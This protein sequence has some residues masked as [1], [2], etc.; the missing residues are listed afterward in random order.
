MF[1]QAGDREMNRRIPV[2]AGLMMLAVSISTGGHFGLASAQAS[3]PPPSKTTAVKGESRAINK[4]LRLSGIDES[5]DS[6]DSLLM[7]D[8]PEK[9]DFPPEQ[10]EMIQ[11]I[12]NQIY[13]PGELLKDIKS[14]MIR[15]RRRSYVR[16][17]LNWLE[18]PLGRRFQKREL[19]YKVNKT[20][21]E[22]ESFV[23]R[24]KFFPPGEERLNLIE[25]ME[26]AN[27]L[28]KHSLELILAHVRV[29]FQFNDKFR[30]K[31]VQNLIRDLND[32]LYEP[33]REKVLQL[34]LFL[35]QGFSNPELARYTRLLESPAGRWL[36]RA[37]QNTSLQTME[38]I[39]QRVDRLV[40]QILAEMDANNG[41][42]DLLKELVPPGQRYIFIRQRDPFAPLVDPDQG[43][44]RT[45]KK[46]ATEKKLRSFA[47]ELK[48][49]PSIPLE[50]YNRIRNDNPKLYADL[51]YYAD[52][53]ND[54][55]NL[56][57]MEQQEYLE[58]VDIY[59]NLIERANATQRFVM[60]TPVQ[61]H[62]KSLKL[63]GVLWKEDESVALIETQDHKGHSVRVGDFLGPN[64]GIVETIEQGEI[65]VVEQ[66]RDYLGN[67]LTQRRELEFQGSPEKG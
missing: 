33:M 15:T 13:Q 7:L 42:S 55:E 28:T 9:F 4:I 30:N 51:E 53:F 6:I 45:A 44:L 67:I 62:F 3:T 12:M 50:I 38:R 41:D 20:P 40:Q 35:F 66:A 25:R 36:T 17:L 46:E 60:R 49:L 52:F 59:R 16:T 57:N 1:F 27:N 56:R 61:T 37:F 24:L 2:V 43:L 21:E 22:L 63:V 48:T 39:S 18:S 54:Q 5:V 8:Q 14:E 29:L 19:E 65:E 26:I 32:E 23:K 10:L 11:N 34:L 64:F 31:S 47:D 58:A